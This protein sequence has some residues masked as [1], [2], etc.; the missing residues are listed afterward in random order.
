MAEGVVA[1][2]AT[3][4]KSATSAKGLVPSPDQH[5]PGVGSKTDKSCRNSMESAAAPEDANS[6]T[7]Q[8]LRQDETVPDTLVT[9]DTQSV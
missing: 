6:L 3:P 7:T 4:T 2:Q 1:F 5:T 9:E 8:A